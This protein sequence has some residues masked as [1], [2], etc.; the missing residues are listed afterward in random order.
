[1]RLWLRPEDGCGFMQL[2]NWQVMCRRRLLWQPEV[3]LR[4]QVVSFLRSR[5]S[6][7]LC[8]IHYVFSLLPRSTSERL[9]LG[10]ELALGARGGARRPGESHGQV[11]QY[12]YKFQHASS[13]QAS[14]GDRWR[15]GQWMEVRNP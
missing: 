13:H 1:M 6:R 4:S 14:S 2:R 5:L 7:I 9:T 10:V 15:S 12:M 8:L 11:R 3:S